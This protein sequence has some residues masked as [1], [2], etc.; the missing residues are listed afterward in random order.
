MK[1]VIP[2]GAKVSDGTWF[3]QAEILLPRNSK[4]RVVE[5]AHT[6]EDEMHKK[7][8]EEYGLPDTYREMVVEY[9]LPE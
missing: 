3:E 8:I 6:S 4:F 7:F 9:V 1:I 2:K 5:E